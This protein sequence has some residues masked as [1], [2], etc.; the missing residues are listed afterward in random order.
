VEVVKAMESLMVVPHHG[1]VV[2]HSHIYEVGLDDYIQN[3][4][5]FVKKISK[6]PVL[7]NAAINMDLFRQMLADLF[8]KEYSISTMLFLP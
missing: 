7:G 4:C 1:Y 5:N 3:C 2:R 6:I 8:R